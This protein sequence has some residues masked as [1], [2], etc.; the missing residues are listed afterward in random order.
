MATDYDAPRTK[1]GDEADPASE[2]RAAALAEHKGAPTR[3][4]EDGV[5]PLDLPGQD[6]DEELVIAVVP[7]QSDE[8]TCCQCFLVRHNSQRNPTPGPPVCRDC[9]A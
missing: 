9:A 5:E 7:A 2:L 6:L 4:D 1:S 3:D 8:F